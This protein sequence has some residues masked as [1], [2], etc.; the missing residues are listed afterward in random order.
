MLQSIAGTPIA[1]KTHV[2]FND[3]QKLELTFDAQEPGDYVWEL[4]NGTEEVGVWKWTDSND[5]V[6]SFYRRK[7]GCRKLRK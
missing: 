2:N 7:P 6:V 4:S 1:E 5:P 3:N